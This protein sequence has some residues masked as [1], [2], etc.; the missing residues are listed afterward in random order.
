LCHRV[1]RFVDKHKKEIAIDTAAAVGIA[2]VIVVAPELSPALLAATARFGGSRAAL[3]AFAAAKGAQEGE[4]ALGPRAPSS[5]T[6]AARTIGAL[7]RLKE[8]RP[9]P[10]PSLIAINNQLRKLGQLIVRNSR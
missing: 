2:A 6:N 10:E 3:T 9:L 1:V 4:D 7:L 5:V 8:V